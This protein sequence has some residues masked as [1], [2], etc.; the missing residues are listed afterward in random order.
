M[1]ITEFSCRVQVRQESTVVY[2]RRFRQF[3]KKKEF[4]ACG[5]V[6]SQQLAYLLYIPLY[7][8]HVIH[9]FLEIQKCPLSLT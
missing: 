9:I 4:G 6:T 7:N 3:F 8:F 1:P 2:F 5:E